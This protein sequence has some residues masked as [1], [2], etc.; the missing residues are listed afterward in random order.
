MNPNTL[1]IAQEVEYMTCL[2]KLGVL[3][4]TK[5]LWLTTCSRVDHDCSLTG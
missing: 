5:V 4:P 3:Q 2:G 1:K